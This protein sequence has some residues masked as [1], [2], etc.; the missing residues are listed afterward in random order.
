[1]F[2]NPQWRSI[3]SL[4]R[5]PQAAICVPRSFVRTNAK[6]WQLGIARTNC[7]DSQTNCRRNLRHLLV[8]LLWQALRLWYVIRK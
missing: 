3:E 8:T 4:L 7:R 6:M 1:M 5:K 2:Q